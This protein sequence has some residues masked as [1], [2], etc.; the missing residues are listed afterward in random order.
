ML[1]D[2]SSAADAQS[3]I[4]AQLPLAEK[5]RLAHVVIHNDGDRQQ[6]EEQVSGAGCN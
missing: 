1:R 2:G 6:L 5:Q 3:R 4:D